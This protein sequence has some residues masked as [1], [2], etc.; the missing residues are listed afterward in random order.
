LEEAISNPDVGVIVAYH[1][2]I[3]SK[4]KQLTLS[5]IKQSIVLKTIAN[6]LSIYSPHSALDNCVGGSNIALIT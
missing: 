6:G 5:D 1:P 3:F 2:P 4:L